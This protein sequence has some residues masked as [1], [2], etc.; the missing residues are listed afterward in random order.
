MKPRP[1]ILNQAL[2]QR[3]DVS[4]SII[5]VGGIRQ[6][7]FEALVGLPPRRRWFMAERS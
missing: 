7:Y 1:I 5:P 6:R 2:S 3:W 4:V